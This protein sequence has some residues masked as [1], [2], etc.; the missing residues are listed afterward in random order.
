MIKELSEKMRQLLENA[1]SS[2]D[3]T[4]SITRLVENYGLKG[5]LPRLAAKEVAQC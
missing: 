2:K 4:E 3:V 5:I 1:K